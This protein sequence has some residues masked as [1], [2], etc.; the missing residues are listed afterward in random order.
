MVLFWG[1]IF[2]SV[3]LGGRFFIGRRKFNRRN[4]AGIEEYENYTSALANSA[5]DRI[6]AIGS[7]ILIIFGILMTL[8][9]FIGK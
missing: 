4:V 3:G 7:G 6:T 2:F 1:L 5:F 9:F 8:T